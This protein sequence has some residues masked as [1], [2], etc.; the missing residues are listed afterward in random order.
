MFCVYLTTYVGNKMPMFYIGSTSIE[1]IKSGYLGSVSSKQFKH[2]WKAEIG[3]NRNLFKLRVISVY[4]T[5]AEALIREHHL[6]KILKV[7]E[8]PLYINQANAIP[9]GCFGRGFKGSENPM[10]GIKRPDI[11]LRM[12]T[13]N[14]M[15]NPEVAAKVT[16]T[17]KEMRRRGTT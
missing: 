13:E 6:H 15:K 9:D 3:A 17:K 10:Y 14:P 11:S 4:K 7:V 16:T 12:L 1:K 2:I 8:S 5:R